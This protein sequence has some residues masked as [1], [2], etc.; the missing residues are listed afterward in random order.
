MFFGS[1][2]KSLGYGLRALTSSHHQ[3][4]NRKPAD[5]ART[6]TIRRRQ[7]WPKTHEPP[8]EATTLVATLDE[9]Q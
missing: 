2:D 4:G 1:S 7:D 3:I 5:S 8:S 6:H 9:W